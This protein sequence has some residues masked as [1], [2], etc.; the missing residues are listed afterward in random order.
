VASA[1]PASLETT[2]VVLALFILLIARRTYRTLTGARYSAGRMFGFVGF[3]FAFFALFVTTTVYAA[4]GTWGP[5]GW[6]LLA[7][8]GATACVV[9]A[10]T[11]PH[12]RHV[13]RFERRD[14]GTAYYRLPWL[15]PVLYLS[16]YTARLVVEVVV[17]G[18]SSLSSPSFPSS[19]PE[20]VL[21]IAAA[22]DVLYAVSVGL[23]FGRAL[24]VRRAYLDG[25]PGATSTHG[26]A[27]RPLP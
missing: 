14:D 11:Y 17:F 7:P 4:L 24:G 27:G 10:Y 20:G 15:V 25:V 8:D 16:L 21:V 18:L 1:P 6:A 23:L 26:A 12:V 2:V 19:L 13:V 22:F 3:A 9:A 5:V